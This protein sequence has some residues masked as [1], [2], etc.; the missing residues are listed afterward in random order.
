MYFMHFS[1]QGVSADASADPTWTA[2]HFEN[3]IHFNPF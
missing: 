3:R 2:D 1:E